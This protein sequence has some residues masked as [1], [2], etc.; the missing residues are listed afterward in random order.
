MSHIR[1]GEPQSRVDG[2]AKVT[3][4][5]RY[6][7]DVNVPGLLY[8]VVVSSAIARGRIARM[9]TSRARSIPG[10]IEVF[11]LAGC[12]LIPFGPK[13]S[14]QIRNR[15]RSFRAGRNGRSIDSR[16]LVPVQVESGGLQEVSQERRL[17]QFLGVRV[18][19]ACARW[20]ST[21]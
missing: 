4:H 5:A 15:V 3:G 16:G 14:S 1:I 17:R 18:P 6:A 13:Q 12:H 20:P 10:V 8:G 21:T 19:V 11:T 9:D 7:A 2:P